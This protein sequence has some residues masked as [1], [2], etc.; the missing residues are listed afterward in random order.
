MAAVP[1]QGGFVGTSRTC[2]SDN[3]SRS[4]SSVIMDKMLCCAMSSFGKKINPVPEEIDMDVALRKLKFEGYSIDTLTDIQ[5]E[6]LSS[7][8]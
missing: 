3:P 4:I 7:A 2:E 1:R 8:G 6:Y 5:R